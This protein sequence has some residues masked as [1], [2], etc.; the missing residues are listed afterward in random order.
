MKRIVGCAGLLMIVCTV[1]LAQLKAAEP[2]YVGTWNLD[3]AKSKFN[4]GP[5]P[6]SQVSKIEAVQDGLKVV[7]DRVEADNTKVHFEWT[8]KFDGKEYPVKGDPNRDTVSVRKLDD[9]TI[10]VTSRKGGKVITTIKGVYAKDGKSRVE[11]FS[12]VDPQ[13]RKYENVTVWDKK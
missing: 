9:Y 5:A 4:P 1:A 6:K 11:T 10:E 13:G 3:T 7:V 12:G 8:A 2:V